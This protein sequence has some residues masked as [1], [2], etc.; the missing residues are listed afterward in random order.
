MRFW[1]KCRFT[2]ELER[3]VCIWFDPHVGGGIV[4]GMFKGLG[5]VGLG[6]ATRTDLTNSPL[7]GTVHDS[8]S[9]VWVW[10]IVV[11]RNIHGDAVYRC[12]HNR[13]EGVEGYHGYFFEG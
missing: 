7:T 13:L 8:I 10:E 4:P 6:K 1:G 5:L 9:R 11:N 2:G 3:C 12:V